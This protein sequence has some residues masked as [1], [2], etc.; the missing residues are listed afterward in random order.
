MGALNQYQPVKDPKKTKA[1]SDA[2]L[3]ES[4]RSVNEIKRTVNNLLLQD[5][6]IKKIIPQGESKNPLIAN[7]R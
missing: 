5:P 3:I 6:Q 4:K 1:K 2:K 7:F